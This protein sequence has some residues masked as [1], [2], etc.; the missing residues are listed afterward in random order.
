MKSNFG[1]V[2]A[3]SGSRG[4]YELRKRLTQLLNKYPNV[5]I[6]WSGNVEQSCEFIRQLKE[7][8]LEPDLGK[9]TKDENEE[10]EDKPMNL[11]RINEEKENEDS[12]LLF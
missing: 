8:K 2:D 12:S 6:I 4:R 3:M 1:Y 11:P 5:R 7:D 10:S 9:F